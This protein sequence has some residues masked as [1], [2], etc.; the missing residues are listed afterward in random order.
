MEGGILKQT[1]NARVEGLG[2]YFGYIPNT[3]TISTIKKG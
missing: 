1:L 3:V 2:E